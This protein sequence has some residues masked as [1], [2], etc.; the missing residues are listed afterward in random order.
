MLSNKD[1]TKIREIKTFFNDSWTQPEFFSKQLSLFKFSKTS[2]IFKSIKQSGVPVWDI[3]SVLFVLPFSNNSTIN[4]LYS[5]KISIDNKSKKDTY[6]R[7]LGNQKINW[8]TILL[9]FVKRYLILENKFDNSS[10]TPKWTT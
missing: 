7:F 5:S 3:L 9:L 4:S 6:Y 1:I 2:K 8:R 10:D